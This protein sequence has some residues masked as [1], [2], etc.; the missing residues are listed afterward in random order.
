[1]D[2]SSAAPRQRPWTVT[3]LIAWGIAGALWGLF[4]GDWQA[5]D[6]ISLPLALLFGWGFWTGKRWAYTLTFA[7]AV[8]S[9]IFLA[10]YVVTGSTRIDTLGKVLW[11]I[12]VAGTLY[13]LLHPATK[14]FIGIDKNARRE[15][16]TGPPDR[17][18]RAAQAAAVSIFGILAVAI[19]LLWTVDML[20]GAL[21]IAALVA[22]VGAG[23]A[24]LVLGLPA[25]VDETQPPITRGTTR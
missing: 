6:L 14:G 5:T 13:L 16:P 3:T 10:G 15:R 7:G 21:L 9:G 11:F 23:I 18:G 19:P 4:F 17:G 12:N 8:L 20:G 22:C 24:V 2:S 25:K 1:M